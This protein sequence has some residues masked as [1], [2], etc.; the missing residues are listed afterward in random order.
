MSI[1]DEKYSTRQRKFCCD[2]A[3]QG[4]NRNE[5]ERRHLLVSKAEKIRNTLEEIPVHT[6]IDTSSL[7]RTFPDIPEK[8]CCKVL[9]RM[10]KSGSLVRLTKGLYYRPK[11]TRFGTVPM[12]EDEI[13]R[14]YTE[15]IKALSWGMPCTADTV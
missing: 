13:I 2:T 8:T 12:S 3:V 6:L 9:E 1:K 4:T 11:K 10:V 5:L 7:C 14:Y 15:I